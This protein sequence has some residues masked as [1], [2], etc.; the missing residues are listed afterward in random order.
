MVSNF[1]PF[2]IA[3]STCCVCKAS[4]RNRWTWFNTQGGESYVLTLNFPLRSDWRQK[5]KW[6]ERKLNAIWHSCQLLILRF[7]FQVFFFFFTWF[8]T[9]TQNETISLI[10]LNLV[11]EAA[12]ES[13]SHLT[14]TEGDINS[15]CNSAHEFSLVTPSTSDARKRTRPHFAKMEPAED[16][17]APTVMT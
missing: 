17:R 7:L 4:Q 10:L 1:L 8:K 15:D 14:K 16:K 5:R 2:Q 13:P 3:E 11:G 12:V 9:H 6:H